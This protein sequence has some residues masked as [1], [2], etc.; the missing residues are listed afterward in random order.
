MMTC[1][2]CGC[3]TNCIWHE[4]TVTGDLVKVCYQCRQTYQC[5]GVKNDLRTLPSV[6]GDEV[7]N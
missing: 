5:K 7:S 4:I 2:L 6:Q 3:E 1:E